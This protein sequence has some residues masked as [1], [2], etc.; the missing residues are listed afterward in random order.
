ME[1]M[2]PPTKIL[3]VTI[4]HKCNFKC[5]H[6][7][8]L[9]VGKSDDHDIKPGYRLTWAQIQRL[10]ADCNSIRDERFAFVINGGYC[11][12]ILDT[13]LYSGKRL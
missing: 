6:C 13:G 12:S 5:A 4:I 11:H 10:I 3:G 2:A 7:G 9:Y 1:N 8:Y